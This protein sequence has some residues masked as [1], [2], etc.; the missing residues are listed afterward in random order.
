MWVGTRVWLVPEGG[1]APRAMV[2]LGPYE[3]NAEKGVVSSGSEA[4]QAMLQRVSGNKV[5]FDGAT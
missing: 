2:V 4:A 1:G 5:K 3:A